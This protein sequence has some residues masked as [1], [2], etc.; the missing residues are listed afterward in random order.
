MVERIELFGINQAFDINRLVTLR[1]RL[2]KL[3]RVDQHI[4][5]LRILI[6]RNDLFR[7]NFPVYWA[8]LLILNTAV[9]F[10]V[11]LIQLDLVP[12]TRSGRVGA[13]WH[14]NQTQAKVPLPHGTSGHGE[15][16]SALVGAQR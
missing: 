7:R 6:S 8:S 11:Q 14:R 9:A 2:F 12:I 15:S 16:T 4:L 10:G 5:S 3:L 13:D 1:S